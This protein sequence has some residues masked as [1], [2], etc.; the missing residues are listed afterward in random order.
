[1]PEVLPKNGKLKVSGSGKWINLIKHFSVYAF[2]M[3]KF[4]LQITK[5][6][7]S[8]LFKNYLFCLSASQNPTSLFSCLISRHLV[9]QNLFSW[10]DLVILRRIDP[11]TF[12][13]KYMDLFLTLLV[14]QILLP[15]MSHTVWPYLWFI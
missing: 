9:A 8:N 15:G 4:F 3:V 1:M 5:K 2:S 12:G 10:S 13:Y 14:W 7:F 11:I 6:F